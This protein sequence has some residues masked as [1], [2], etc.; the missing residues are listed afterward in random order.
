MTILNMMQIM[1]NFSAHNDHNFKMQIY[2]FKEMQMCHWVL[3]RKLKIIEK[4]NITQAPML[5]CFIPNSEL[6][7][8]SR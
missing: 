7:H 6:F 8:Y 2:H 1:L 3:I 4:S 5:M